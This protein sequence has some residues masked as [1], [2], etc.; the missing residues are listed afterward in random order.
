MKS[1]KR[2]KFLAL[3]AAGLVLTGCE[4]T[5]ST[6]ALKPKKEVEISYETDNHEIY[7]QIQ[8]EIEREK[9]ELNIEKVKELMEMCETMAKESEA[10]HH[11]D[12][13]ITNF[14]QE[15]REQD[16]KGYTEWTN[17]DGELHTSESRL[18]QDVYNMLKNIDKFDGLIKLGDNEYALYNEEGGINIS[19]V[20]PS[21]F[22]HDYTCINTDKLKLFLLLLG[23][24]SFNELMEKM[25]L[26]A[27]MDYRVDTEF[28]GKSLDPDA[29]QSSNMSVEFK[30]KDVESVSELA[31]IAEKWMRCTFSADEPSEIIAATVNM[32]S[33]D[34]TINNSKFAEWFM[35]P[36]CPYVEYSSDGK[37]T[38]FSFLDETKKTA[39]ITESF[40]TEPDMCD[41]RAL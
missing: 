20:Y 16:A 30:G 37:N 36:T 1:K 19:D 35:N 24:N 10:T 27:K 22:M 2:S 12:A 11:I 28:I 25:G 34:R 33:F 17:P 5:Q 39:P 40:R 41:A 29:V 14:E 13:L 21:R 32:L 7:H 23:K 26:E 18:Y 9:Q 15:N 31:K 3:L 8:A 38:T 4:D 6:E